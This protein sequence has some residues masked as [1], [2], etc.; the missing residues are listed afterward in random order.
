M[1]MPKQSEFEAL[2]TGCDDSRDEEGKLRGAAS[3]PWTPFQIIT[4][5]LAVA[6]GLI[7]GAF[8]G[9]VAVVLSGFVPVC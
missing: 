1:L 2:R 3:V 7:I 6:L 5:T 4:A 9:A 8:G